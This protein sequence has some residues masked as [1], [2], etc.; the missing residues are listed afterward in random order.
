LYFLKLNHATAG[1]HT[2]NGAIFVLGVLLASRTA[3]RITV[4]ISCGIS[5]D[6]QQ[7]VP[8]VRNSL[9]IPLR[10]LSEYDDLAQ[11]QD[12]R[13]GKS[14]LDKLGGRSVFQFDEPFVFGAL[15]LPDLSPVGF[16][17]GDPHRQAGRPVS[18]DSGNWLAR[19]G[20]EIGGLPNSKK[21]FRTSGG[22]GDPISFRTELHGSGIGSNAIAFTQETHSIHV[23]KTDDP[24][25]GNACQDRKSGMPREGDDGGI[26]GTKFPDDFKVDR[27]AD[28]DSAA[29][30]SLSEPGFAGFHGHRLDQGWMGLCL[31]G[32][33]GPRIPTAQ[34][35]NG[36]GPAARERSVVGTEQGVA[37]SQPEGIDHATE[38]VIMT[39]IHRLAVV[40]E[41]VNRA[42]AGTGGQ[43]R[44]A[45]G[46]QPQQ[47]REPV[48]YP[49]ERNL[50]LEVPLTI[51]LLIDLGHGIGL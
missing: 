34:E 46:S 4:G 39:D 48:P 15:R 18:A 6:A 43:E 25:A 29:E 42:E 24:I 26:V 45:I 37:L 21:E 38:P 13:F 23:P 9:R 31:G 19:I 5:A 3:N 16:I 49:R 7:R 33:A 12:A 11:V 1:W 44:A 30:P 41:G 50:R 2:P 20:A 14:D 51:G 40:G 8:T 47:L 28:P 10:L 36:I 35:L 22:H 27:I 17:V 32:S